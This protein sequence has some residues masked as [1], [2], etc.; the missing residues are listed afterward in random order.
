VDM[1]QLPNRDSNLKQKSGCNKLRKGPKG[2]WLNMEN[3]H[4]TGDEVRSSSC[5]S[6]AR[7]DHF[8]L[9]QLCADRVA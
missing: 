1:M 3:P 9:E 4:S 2:A 6:F 7:L 8:L 5:S